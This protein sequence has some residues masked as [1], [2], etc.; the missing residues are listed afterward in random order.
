MNEVFLFHA[1]EPVEEQATDLQEAIRGPGDVAAALVEPSPGSATATLGVGTVI[2]T[3]LFS[4]AVK[5]IVKV[6]LDRLEQ[7]LRKKWGSNGAKQRFKVRIVVEDTETMRS[8]EFVIEAED[9]ASALERTMAKLK[10]SVSE[11]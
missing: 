9:D 6:G 7:Y 10:G 11:G 1:D 4:E 3:I 2:V 8:T 5:R